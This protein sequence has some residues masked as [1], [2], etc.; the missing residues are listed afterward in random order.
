MRNFSAAGL[1]ASAIAR[2]ANATCSSG[3]ETRLSSRTQVGAW[4]LNGSSV[5]ARTNTNGVVAVVVPSKVNVP[6]DEQFV[7]Q[8]STR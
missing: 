3:S 5:A 7:L 1:S 6:P 8:I 2:C 4:L